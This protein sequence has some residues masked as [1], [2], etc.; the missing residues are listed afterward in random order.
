MQQVKANNIVEISLLHDNICRIFS[1]TIYFF[2]R[3][4][5]KN[6]GQWNDGDGVSISDQL[7]K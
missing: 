2:K 5:P 6:S 1:I 7:R 4:S 3:M